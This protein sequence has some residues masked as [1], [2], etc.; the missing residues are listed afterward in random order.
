VWVFNSLT[1]GLPTWYIVGGTSVSAPTWAGIVNAAGGFAA[2]SQA[3]LT[4]L[5]TDPPGD[6]TDITRGS[7]G[8]YMGNF[9]VANWD[10]CSGLGSPKKYSGK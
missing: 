2:S 10:F 1:R 6:F 3:E 8:P 9:A 5:Y 4:K 7:C